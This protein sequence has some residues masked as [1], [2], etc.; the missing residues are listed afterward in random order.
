MIEQ[1]KMLDL[2]KYEK[3]SKKNRLKELEKE[4]E[5]VLIESTK[6]DIVKSK[7]STKAKKVFTIL[8]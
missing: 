2:L 3:R 1:R 7:I 4:Y 6:S 8:L 5:L